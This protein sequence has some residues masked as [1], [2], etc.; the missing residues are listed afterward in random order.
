MATYAPMTA[1]RTNMMRLEIRP[2]RYTGA[3]STEYNS[4]PMML[5]V[6]MPMKTT[7][8]VVF[9]LVSPAVFCACHV[10]IRGVMA[11]SAET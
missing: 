11:A 3:S 1:T 5:P 6:H 4:G 10:K 8:D 9:F 7:A 2:G